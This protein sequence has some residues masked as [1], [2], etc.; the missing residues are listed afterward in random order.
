M[1][2]LAGAEVLIWSP[3]HEDAGYLAPRPVSQV[4][5]SPRGHAAALLE[6]TQI[7]IIG[8]QAPVRPLFT[9]PS[10]T[11][12]ARAAH[13]RWDD[14]GLDLAVC[15]ARGGRWNY[16]RH[17]GRAKDD[18]PPH[19]EPCSPPRPHNQP[20]PIAT[21]EDAPDLAD[22]DVGPHLPAGGWKLRHHRY[23]TRDLV[24]L[25]AAA[26]RVA[27]S[28]PSALPP[29]AERLLHFEPLDDIGSEEVVRPGDSVSFLERDERL[30]VMQVGDELRFYD[31]PDGT[32]RVT[33]KGNLLGRCPDGH[34]LAWEVDGDGY[35]I[36]DA[37]WGATVRTLPR[38]PGFVLGLGGACLSF[39][40]QRLDG[41][42]V[43]YPL[44][45]TGPA[46]GHD[47]ARADSYVF[48]AR[49]F[50]PRHVEPASPPPEGSGLILALGSGA[51]ASID[52]L[53]GRVQVLAYANPRATAI[54]PGHRP[55]EVIFADAAGVFLVRPEAPPTSLHQGTG[56][57][58]WTD[59]SL[60]PDG[61]SLL[62]AAP[63][64]VAALDLR[65]GDL[66]G[67]IPVPGKDHLSRWDDD[68]S[69]LAWSFDRKGRPDGVV[70]PRG[71][72]QAQRVA[73]AVSNLEV[74][75]GRVAIKR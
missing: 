75:R 47:L 31:L 44:A 63:D 61:T 33:R 69:V 39:Y 34:W 16:L 55:G 26:G 6:G 52:E 24:V 53:T 5:L 9:F 46:E 62:L 66:L 32:R 35:R 3:G 37:W 64:R 42:L 30:A 65:S 27:T 15:D 58:D 21:P 74:E 38:E 17:G 73:A 25:D 19:G 20:E 50:A 56:I 60:S 40:T 72:P 12:E 28:P 71:V 7:E 22:R 57:V 2:I 49:P 59:L 48:D 51:I 70:I 29:A 67:S 45:G 1:A 8:D 43:A 36:F 18:P 13:L 14:G 54:T 68:G 41:T 23:L 10:G 4:R 11:E